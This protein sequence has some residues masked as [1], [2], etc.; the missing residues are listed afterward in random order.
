M[1]FPR[2]LSKQLPVFKPKKTGVRAEHAGAQHGQ[3]QLDNIRLNLSTLSVLVERC[4][5]GTCTRSRMDWRGM[6]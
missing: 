1:H 2:F 5:V 3:N 6:N 4:F